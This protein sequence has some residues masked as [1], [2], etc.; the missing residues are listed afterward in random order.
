MQVQPSS[1]TSRSR[2]RG[3][4]AVEVM[5]SMAVLAIGAAGVMSMQ[6]GAIQGNLDARKMDVANS[7]A[8]SWVER[9]RRDATTWTLPNESNV[10]ATSNWSTNTTLIAF[11]GNGTNAG[12]FTFP[13]GYPGGAYRDGFSAATDLLGRDV[14]PSAGAN[15]YPGA[16]F[17]AQIKVDWLVPNEMLRATVRVYW[18]RELYAA[19]AGDF[20]NSNEATGGPDDP[21]ANTIYHFIYTT[22]AVRRNPGR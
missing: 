17:C 21:N 15:K 1:G 14:A 5:L 4:T 12:R 9:L 3:Y 18:R 16:Q 19:P 10:S 22:T 6:K 20:C 8:R 13:T 7:V 2:A 11:F